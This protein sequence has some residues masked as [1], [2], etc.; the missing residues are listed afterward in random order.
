MN[1]TESIEPPEQRGAVMSLCKNYHNVSSIKCDKDFDLYNKDGRSI[2]HAIMLFE[3]SEEYQRYIVRKLHPLD[4]KRAAFKD[5]KAK[6][7]EPYG[8]FGPSFALLDAYCVIDVIDGD[9]LGQEF[10]DS[11]QDEKDAYLFL[12]EDL[13]IIKETISAFIKE[14]EIEL[15][16][17]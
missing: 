10:L 2:W 6:F 5:Y 4:K 7:L 17:L 9:G 13:R 15:D 11:V 14:M 12:K 1:L 3:I 8:H 16:S